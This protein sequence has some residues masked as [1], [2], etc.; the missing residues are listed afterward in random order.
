VV[1]DEATDRPGREIPQDYREIVEHLIT[2]Q[3]WRYDKRG[4]GHPVL[5]P[6]DRSQ[7][8]LRVPTTPTRDA[9]AIKN[10]VADIR[11]RGGVWPPPQSH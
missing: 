6:A 1:N 4:K 11:R 2:V 5:Y 3:G 7:P 10:F 9:R 8:Q